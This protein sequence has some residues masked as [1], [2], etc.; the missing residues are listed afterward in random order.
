MRGAVDIDIVLVQSVLCVP[1]IRC[2]VVENQSKW[3]TKLKKLILNRP[4][5]VSVRRHEIKEKYWEHHFVIRSNN[6][7]QNITFLRHCLL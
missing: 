2:P 6:I 7:S 5:F 3:S 4:F 1:E